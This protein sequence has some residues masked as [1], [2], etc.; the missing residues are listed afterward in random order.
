[1]KCKKYAACCVYIEELHLSSCLSPAELGLSIVEI[2]LSC[3]MQ[4][5]T[6]YCIRY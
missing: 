2:M 4:H 6:V 3:V 5:V 1:M